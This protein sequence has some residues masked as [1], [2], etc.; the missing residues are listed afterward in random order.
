MLG[1]LAARRRGMQNGLILAGIQMA[2]LPLCLM[3][4]ERAESAA[5][6]TRSLQ[7]CLMGE[8]NV[9]LSLFQL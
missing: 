2:P 8:I 3:I 4:I 9:H 7:I 6:G 1:T 5:F